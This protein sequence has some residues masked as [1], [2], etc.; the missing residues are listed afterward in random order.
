MFTSCVNIENQLFSND[1]FGKAVLMLC[2][3]IDY[4]IFSGMN[5]I[6]PVGNDDFYNISK[7]AWPLKPLT[8]IGEFIAFWN[9]F[10]RRV[11]NVPIIKKNLN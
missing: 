3:T 7:L 10:L 9:I 6:L 5:L 4:I 8:S 11:R 1:C 2:K